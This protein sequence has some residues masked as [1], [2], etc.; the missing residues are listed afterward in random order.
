MIVAIITLAAGYYLGGAL[1]DFFFQ[2]TP[3]GRVLTGMAGVLAGMVF[4]VLALNAPVENR[5]LFM[6]LLALTGINMSLSAPNVVATV[7]DVVEPEVRGTAQA[8]LSLAENIGSAV[9]PFLAGIIA[10]QSSLHT[11]ILAICV[12]TWIACALLLGA[13][14][15]WIPRDIERLRDTMRARAEEELACTS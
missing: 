9:A 4:L 12:T 14:A 3:R 5:V 1:G 2:R 11:A 8:M 15:L 10:M 6:L 13:T 7:Q